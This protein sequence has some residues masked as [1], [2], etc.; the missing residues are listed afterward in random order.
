MVIDFMLRE[1][2]LQEML[3]PKTQQKESICWIIGYML[4]LLC[5]ALLISLYVVG[6]VQVF[7]QHAECYTHT[8]INLLFD[9]ELMYQVGLF[10]LIIDTVNSNI[11]S[12][13]LRYTAS[14]KI[15][16]MFPY[17]VFEWIIRV[18]TLG[19]TAVQYRVVSSN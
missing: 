9:I 4:S 18:V 5:N 19:V 7:S 13:Y 10:V 2:I 11:I 12:V 16:A 3:G 17:E 8:G 15:R 14:D 1:N 6:V